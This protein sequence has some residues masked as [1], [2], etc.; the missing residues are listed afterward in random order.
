MDQGPALTQPSLAWCHWGLWNCCFQGYFASKYQVWM[1]PNCE[2]AACC[3]VSKQLITLTSL[4]QTEHCSWLKKATH[5]GSPS[6][7]NGAQTWN[8]PAKTKHATTYLI[9]PLAI[10]EE[11][12]MTDMSHITLCRSGRCSDIT[13]RRAGEGIRWS[14]NSQWCS[15]PLC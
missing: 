10:I 8:N 5:T 1:T 4:A 14:N 6:S 15:T 2:M 7:R 11:S 13:L 9:F 12:H 3:L